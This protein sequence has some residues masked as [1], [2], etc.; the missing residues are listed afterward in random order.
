MAN[1][2]PMVRA[3]KMTFIKWGKSFCSD[4]KSVLYW[5]GEDYGVF[6]SCCGRKV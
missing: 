6:L 2:V 1:H 5:F 4:K 3:E